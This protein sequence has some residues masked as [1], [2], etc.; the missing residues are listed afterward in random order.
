MIIGIP[1]ERKPDERRVALIPDGARVLTNLGHRVLLETQAG[2]LSGFSDDDFKAAG[3]EIVPDLKSVWGQCELLVK[4][5]EP[6]PDE[7]GFFRPGLAVFCFLHLAVA[8]E[9]TKAMV[10]QKVTG[11]DYDLVTLDDG[12]LPILEPMSVIAGKLSIQCGAYALQA[13]C[14]G[15][16][17]LLGG[18]VGVQP[19]KIV[20]VGAGAAGSNA[21]RVALGIGAEVSILDIN[22]QKL[23]PFAERIPPT[24]TLFSTPDTLRREI[25]EAD[26]VIGS[27]LVP[28]ALAPKLLTREMLTTM[29]KGSVIVDICIDQGGFAESSRPTTISNPTFVEDDVVHYCV[30]NMPALVPRT[31]TIALTNSTLL[32]IQRIAGL[33]ITGAVRKSPPLRRSLTSYKGNLT[34]AVI[35]RDLNMKFLTE[36]EVNELLID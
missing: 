12:R 7:I 32:W 27:V 11:L 19:G 30:T 20:V 8:P 35:G 17:V 28:G 1:K 22:P 3:A 25:A 26:L 13:N 18:A 36:H 24:K 31:S 23:Q 6:S 16:G 15:R 33:G 10:E 2:A 9:L 34:N 14:G 29:K 4:V 5:K 21:A